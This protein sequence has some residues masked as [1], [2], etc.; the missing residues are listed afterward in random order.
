MSKEQQV[1]TYVS[2]SRHSSQNLHR[3]EQYMEV[4]NYTTFQTGDSDEVQ[5]S[6]THKYYEFERNEPVERKN[7][8]IKGR[9][10]R[11]NLSK[12]LDRHVFS[13]LPLTRGD[14]NPQTDY[15]YRKHHRR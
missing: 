15:E 4:T 10:K 9:C 2:R 14:E 8:T 3:P 5:F 1:T 7:T 13:P 6:G 11:E 12:V